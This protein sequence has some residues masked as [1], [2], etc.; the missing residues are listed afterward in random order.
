[1]VVFFFFLGG[2]GGCRFVPV[3]AVGVVTAVDISGW[4]LCC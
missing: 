2:I 3:L 1:M 4:W